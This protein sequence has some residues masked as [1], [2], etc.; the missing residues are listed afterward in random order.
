MLQSY[1]SRNYSQDHIT[2]SAAELISSGIGRSFDYEQILA[3][4]DT[5]RR[6]TDTVKYV[7]LFANGT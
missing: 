2:H 3:P 5:S 1:S 4:C 6:V 7:G